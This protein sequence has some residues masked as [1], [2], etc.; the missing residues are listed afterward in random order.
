M[1]IVRNFS[2]EVNGKVMTLDRI[3]GPTL[4]DLH[5][6]LHCIYDPYTPRGCKCAKE[7]LEGTELPPLNWREADGF[8]IVALANST[9]ENIWA[10][11]CEL[12]GLKH[13]QLSV[14]SDQ[15]LG[16]SPYI[17]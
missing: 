8:T 1:S 13:E 11:Y 6:Y 15:P 17:L 3:D 9:R 16:P 14:W 7:F 10:E 12:R 5:M 2:I 4:E